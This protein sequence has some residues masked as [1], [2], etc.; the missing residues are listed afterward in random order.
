MVHLSVPKTRRG[1]IE[2]QTLEHISD[3]DLGELFFSTIVGYF[4]HWR[5]V[6]EKVLKLGRELVSRWLTIL[7]LILIVAISNYITATSPN[8]TSK[9]LGGI[10]TLFTLSDKVTTTYNTA[11]M[12]FP[13]TNMAW[14]QVV[15]TVGVFYTDVRDFLCVKWPP[16]SLSS[17]CPRLIDAFSIFYNLFDYITTFVNIIDGF[18]NQL[19]KSL[20]NIIC[21]KGICPGSGPYTKKNTNA[22]PVMKHMGLENSASAGVEFIASGLTNFLLFEWL[23]EFLSWLVSDF[24]ATVVDMIKLLLKEVVGLVQQDKILGFRDIWKLVL[25][26]T[27]IIV[28]AMTHLATDLFF[29]F[30][31]RLLCS[32]FVQP[33]SCM[34]QDI[35]KVI[36]KDFWIPLP[37]FCFF[38]KCPRLYLPIGIVCSVFVG[39]CYCYA[40]KNPWG[41]KV[42]CVLG[43]PGKRRACPCLFILSIYPKIDFILSLVGISFFDT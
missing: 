2:I 15:L 33:V 7:F 6:L 3:D 42:P 8:F 17:D 41:V 24:L 20:S 36:F 38:G 27:A 21:P 25:A 31:D 29:S 18:I 26:S 32:V 14:N 10:D 1:I 37:F 13:E 39:T 19:K 11:A 43:A 12:F 28:K 23:M 5:V 35:C 9:A 22:I 30:F 16:T 34:M 4:I 40:C